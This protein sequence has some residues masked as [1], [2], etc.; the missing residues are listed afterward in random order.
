MAAET[1]LG[2]RVFFSRGG[3]VEGEPVVPPPGHVAAAV[4]VISPGTELRSLAASRDGSAR[5]A[6]SMCLSPPVRLPGRDSAVCVLAPVPHGAPL[7]VDHPRAL[8]VP[9][10]IDVALAALARFQFIAALTPTEMEV[11]A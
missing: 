5:P 2:A 10:G 6:G 9:A 3:V 11:S 7:P 8:S 4:S 1:P